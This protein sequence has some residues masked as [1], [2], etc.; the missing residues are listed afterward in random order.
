M[1]FGY[2]LLGHRSIL[3]SGRASLAQCRRNNGIR[4]FFGVPDLSSL[5]PFS[6]NKSPEGG[7]D[8]QKY[9]ERKVLPYS[10][11]QLYDLVADVDNYYRFV[12]YCVESKVLTSKPVT[13]N[14]THNTI[15]KK[16]ARLTVGFLAF[17]ESYVSEVICR[18]YESVKAVAASDTP[19]FKKLTTTWRFNPTN[20]IPPQPSKTGSV[21][22]DP[23]DQ[24]PT[25]LSIDLEFAFSNPLY[26]AVSSTFFKQ[27]SS[28]MV[29]AF[30]NRC[31]EVYG[32]G[33][34]TYWFGA[35]MLRVAY[36]VK[37]AK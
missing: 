33:G 9:Q 4:T 17:K 35:F 34:N 27:V 15:V 24:G 18:P 7:G 31:I 22:T 19:L 28:M 20:K 5:S 12:P 13:S 32:R 14:V 23:Y 21:S 16:D 10:Q 11:K 36:V 3:L 1:R 6:N 37:S 2:F 29:E 8:E 26:A 30:E 25:L